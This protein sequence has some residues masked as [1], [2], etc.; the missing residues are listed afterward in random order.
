MKI[1]YQKME[2]GASEGPEQEVK[3]YRI[4]NSLVYEEGG[5]T[6]RLILTVEQW[7]LLAQAASNYVEGA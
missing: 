5:K 3:L 1:A 6:H 4:G 7:K 2:I